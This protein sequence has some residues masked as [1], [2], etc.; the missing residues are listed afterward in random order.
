VRKLYAYQ[1]L[2]GPFYIAVTTDGRYHPVFDDDSLGSYI[3][4]QQA[5]DDLAGGHTFSIAGGVDTA[6]LGIPDELGEWERVTGA[7]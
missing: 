7:G 4:P 3:N 5:V 1:T 6:K 2:I